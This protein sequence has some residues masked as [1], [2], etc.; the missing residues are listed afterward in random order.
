[1]A[2][3]IS[4]QRHRV[5]QVPR[6]DCQVESEEFTFLSFVLFK[7]ALHS[8]LYWFKDLF[9]ASIDKLLSVVY[10]YVLYD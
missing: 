5:M 3:P 1:M 4:G 2:T 6:L 9:K 7:V 8:V 10:S